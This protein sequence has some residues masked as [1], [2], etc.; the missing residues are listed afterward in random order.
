MATG[1]LTTDLGIEKPTDEE[2]RTGVPAAPAPEAPAAPAPEAAPAAEPAAVAPTEPAAAPEPEEVDYA[3]LYE[4]E[5]AARAAE[6]A[7]LLRAAQEARAR[8]VMPEQQ[9]APTEPIAPQT[10]PIKFDERGNAYIEAPVPPPPPPPNPLYQAQQRGEQLRQSLIL[11]DPVAN[12][13]PVNRIYNAYLTLDQ[14]VGAKLAQVPAHVR[15]IDDVLAYI[16]QTGLDREIATQFP[17]VV[18]T[19]EDLELLV[20]AGTELSERKVRRLMRSTAERT[21][22][23]A[24]AANGGAPAAAPVAAASA[25]AAPA[26]SVIGKPRS[27][28]QR[29][30]GQSGAPTDRLAELDAKD[31]W[32]WTKEEAAEYARLAKGA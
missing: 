23:Y 14:M 5:K 26:A 25:A 1:F 13:G 16:N 11:E 17:D 4:A 29:G 21:R 2:L 19:Y 12:A 20:E 7:G 28:A 10:V 30:E 22:E 8:Q 24:R 6:R 31:P 32:K 9:P 3:A 15:S 27:Q 18:K